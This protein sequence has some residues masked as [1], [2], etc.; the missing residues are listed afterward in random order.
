MLG[1]WPSAGH[2]CVKLFVLCATVR[3]TRKSFCK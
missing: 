3:K 2:D 1:D